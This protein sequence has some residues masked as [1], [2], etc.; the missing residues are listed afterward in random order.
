MKI[1]IA[2]MGKLGEYLA[3]ELSLD[4]NEVTIIDNKPLINNNILNNEEVFFI[5]GNALDANIL[6]EANISSADL[7]ISVMDKDEK[8]IMCCFLGKKL[9]V[10]KTI[11]RV[12]TPEYSAST[13]LF[14]EDLG[15][16]MIIN[17]EYMAAAHIARILSIPNALD[18]IPFFKGRIYMI[19]IKIKEN[20]SLNGINLIQLN[21]KL[22]KRVIVCALKRNNT[23]IIPDGHDEINI[24][25]KLYVTATRENLV[26]FL[27][28]SN[29]VGE[30]NKKIAINGGSATAAYLA[31]MLIEMG[32]Y[33]TIFEINKERCEF[34]TEDIPK[35][36]VINGDISNQ[37]LLFEEHIEEYDAF[38]S[39]NSIDEE[40]I[41]HSM[42]AKSLNIP[43]IITKINHIKLD[44]ITEMADIDTIITPH[45]IASNQ[46][47]K[48]IRAIQ[49]GSKS[50]CESIYIFD[51]EHFE[52]IE[53]T[54]RKEFKGLNIKLK[55]LSIKDN[56]LVVAINRHK[57]IIFPTGE[58]VI[59]EKDTIVLAVGEN[60]DIK[61]V[62]DILE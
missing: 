12:R 2:G 11:A 42:F 8:N 55:D 7:L 15:L 46:I 62:N 43:N 33:V 56:V 1:I 24:G 57:N 32:M 25:D 17:P 53:F 40:N 5:N 16:S 26:E 45:K 21:K 18:T 10:R 27:K 58:D 34:L 4:G 48:Y 36:L 22:K 39:L 44:G 61:N 23:T 54:I 51:K 50:S 35:A 3:K 60:Q 31:K 30:E 59:K 28:F 13:D 47:V 14:K 49:N 37:D 20:S 9:G 6:N 29:L 38:I 41:V 52:M 19:A